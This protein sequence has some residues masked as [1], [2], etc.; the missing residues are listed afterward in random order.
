[1]DLGAEREAEGQKINSLICGDDINESVFSCGYLLWWFERD[2][3]TIN[4]ILGVPLTKDEPPNK[5]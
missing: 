3:E 2:T 5:E 4:A 1:M